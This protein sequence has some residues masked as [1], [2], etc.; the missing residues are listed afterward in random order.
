VLIDFDTL[1]TATREDADRTTEIC[2]HACQGHL[3]QLYNDKHY[4]TGGVMEFIRTG[5]ERRE[6]VVVLAT[7]EHLALFTRQLLQ[8]EPFVQ[9]AIAD[10]Q[11]RFVDAHQALESI[12]IGENPDRHRFESL[13]GPLHQAMRA[14]FG[15]V[16][17]YG[18]LVNL[19][20][21]QGLLHSALELEGIW[22]AYL[23]ENPGTQL[24]CGYALKNLE[25]A[26]D[27]ELV[28]AAHS[29]AI[30]EG[31]DV[32]DLFTI[33]RNEGRM[34]LRVAQERMD[35]DHAE[36]E[37]LE[38]KSWVTRLSRLGLIAD[39]STGLADEIKNPLT[40]IRLLAASISAEVAQLQEHLARARIERQVA[41]LEQAVNAIAASTT[42]MLNFAGASAEL[43]GE[44]CALD[45]VRTALELAGGTLKTSLIDVVSPALDE[46]SR[47]DLLPVRG[48]GSL[49]VQ[50]ILNLLLNAKDAI[51]STLRGRGSV[52]VD[53][54]ALDGTA[55]I[56][57]T[58]DGIGMSP[59]T[60]ERIFEPLFTTKAGGSG[61][62][63][64][65][66]ISRSIVRQHGGEIDCASIPGKG[67]CFTIRLPLK[68]AA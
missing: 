18:E 59:G 5:L 56:E 37:L 67:T 13:V 30:P 49:V 40:E 26:S 21:G 51:Q 25:G 12:M 62:G 7:A 16:R 8:E 33:R 44:F 1:T 60:R 36:R 38:S 27:R 14:K 15:T 57:V 22:N 31:Q 53:V 20:C 17:F 45:T 54:R 68:L 50:A 35:R 48:E 65:L 61:T 39:L 66:S 41:Q 58:D 19:L 28:V 43:A 46:A 10:G 6:G 52:R 11:L 9:E 42:G 3:V 55:E 34:Q 23:K 2:H 24:L 4:L 47:S 32:C 63:M 29:D 64:G